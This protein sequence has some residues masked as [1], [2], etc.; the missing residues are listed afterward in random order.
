MRKFLIAGNWKMHG[1]RSQ[2]EALITGIKQG[3]AALSSPADILVLPTFVHLTQAHALLTNTTILLGAQ[4][5]YLGT[6]GAF[7][8]EIAGPMLVDAGCQYVLVGHSERRT[9]FHEDLTLVAQKFK[10]AVECG[11]KP[12]LCIGETKDERERGETVKI[13]SDQLQSVI[14]LAGIEAFQ[15][16]VIAYEPVW[17][18]GTGLTATPDQAQEVHAFIRLLISQNHVDLAKTIRI[19]YGGSMKPDN[20][21]SLLAMPDIDGGLIGG[22]SLEAN[23]FLKICAEVPT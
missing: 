21:A 14:H 4:N 7:T 15:H 23:S 5:L 1:S 17:A 3:A 20:A 9:L 12:I 16:A 8:G 2:V 11:L 18:I 10:A 13:I 22:A 6:Q 19:L